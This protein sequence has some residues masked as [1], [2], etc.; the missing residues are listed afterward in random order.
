LK[1]TERK[2]EVLLPLNH[3]LVPSFVKPLKEFQG[4]KKQGKRRRKSWK[5]HFRISRGIDDDDPQLC[6]LF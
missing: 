3:I 4:K 5:N 2:E 6:S 1:Q